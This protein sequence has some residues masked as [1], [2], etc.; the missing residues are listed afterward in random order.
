MTELVDMDF[1]RIAAELRR[2]SEEAARAAVR[3]PEQSERLSR[4]ARDLAR[5][6]ERIA[7]DAEARESYIVLNDVA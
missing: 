4:M 7:R 5:A 3:N 1:A 2:E 6:A